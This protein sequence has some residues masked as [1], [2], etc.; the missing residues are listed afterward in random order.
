MAVLM[1][2]SCAWRYL[3]V[4]L[5]VIHSFESKS[6]GRDKKNYYE[7]V[8]TEKAMPPLMDPIPYVSENP[9]MMMRTDDCLLGALL[10]LTLLS[11]S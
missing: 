9:Q 5:I 2:P 8:P 3:L 4:L 11:F 1:I 10:I 7:T 6:V